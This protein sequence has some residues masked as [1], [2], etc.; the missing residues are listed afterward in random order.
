[1]MWNVCYTSLVECQAQ[2]VVFNNVNQDN[3]IRSQM[4]FKISGLSIVRPGG[5]AHVAYDLDMRRF[6]RGFPNHRIGS[7]PLMR[8]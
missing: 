4:M 2:G 5:P 3:Q 6:D 7:R 1:M 8:L